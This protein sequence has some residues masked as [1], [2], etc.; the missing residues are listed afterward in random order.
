MTIRANYD[1][2]IQNVRDNVVSMASMV[3]KAI[4][5]SVDALRTQDVAL[6]RQVK[7]AD[8]EIN[9][10]RWQSE[11]HAL[12]IIATQ[13][14]VAADLRL[15]AAALQVFTDLERMGDH[16]AGI[17]KIAIKTAEEP[18]LKPLIDVPRMAM[19]ARSMLNDAVT[20]FIELDEDAARKVAMR[21]DEIDL[22]Y[23]QVYRELL[24]YMMADPGTINRA[25]N[26]LWVSHNLERIGDRVTNICERVVFTTSG[27]YVSM[28]GGRKKRQAVADAAS[29][30]G[31]SGLS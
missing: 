16:A 23:D 10:F 5:R 11:E 26:L 27:E 12:T 2:E 24:T 3:D 20:A 17:A 21:D 19:A 6:A 9:A 28:D 31:A 29:A 7:A 22:L 15:I 4:A 8:K 13:A 1:H 14:P 18:P 30:S 25:T